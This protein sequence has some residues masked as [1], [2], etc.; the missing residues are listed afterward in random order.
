MD[1]VVVGT[2]E[3]VVVGTTTEGTSDGVVVGTTEGVVV[4]TSEGDSEGVDLNIMAAIAGRI[5]HSDNL[6]SVPSSHF[7][8]GSD[9]VF[10]AYGNSTVKKYC[11]ETA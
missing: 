9:V 5:C 1:G 10:A 11:V 8:Q 4:G 2:S 3:G 6:Q 7:L